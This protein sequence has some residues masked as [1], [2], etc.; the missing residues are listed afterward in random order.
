MRGFEQGDVIEVD[1][2]P[3]IGHEPQ[4]LRPALVVS[5][6]DYNATTSMTLV[7]PL[8]SRDNKFYLH[9]PLSPGYKVSGCVMMEQLRALDLIARKAKKV[10]HL[11]MTDL[12]P[13]LV[14]LRSFF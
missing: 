10:D 6:E 3:T 7:C 2:N 12:E 8:T 13:I 5:N 14:C 1:F 4:N 11:D 9:E